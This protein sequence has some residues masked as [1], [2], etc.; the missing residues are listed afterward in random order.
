MRKVLCRRGCPADSLS[1]R[2]F[3]DVA[4]QEAPPDHS[5]VSRTRW[6][7]DVERHQAVLTWVLKR[8][9]GPV[10]V[11][12]ARLQPRE[13]LPAARAPETDRRVVADQSPAAPRQDWRPGPRPNVTEA[14]QEYLARIDCSP[15]ELFFHIVAVLH[16][17]AYRDDNAGALKQGWPRVPLPK[18]AA[19]LRRGAELGRRLAELIDPE[20]SVPGVTDLHVRPDLMGLGELV[21]APTSVKRNPAPDL[22]VAARW[23]YAG[24]GGVVMPGSGRVT[25]SSSADGFLDIHLNDSTRWKDVP[26]R[27]WNYTL[28]GYQVLKKWLSY[29]EEVLL[30]RPLTSDEAQAFTHNVRRIAAILSLHGQ[31]N[32]HYAAS[33]MPVVVPQGAQPVRAARRRRRQKTD[34]DVTERRP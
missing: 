20:T 8:R 31:L 22:R 6:R 13:S 9:R 23:G 5:T 4:L 24:R 27:V 26:E 7:I 30:G 17:A 2:A 16:A 29:R 19:A 10:A 34:A 28:G 1:L 33:I 14:A 12:R 3:L 25:P 21:G 18:D 11:E 32:E 15:E